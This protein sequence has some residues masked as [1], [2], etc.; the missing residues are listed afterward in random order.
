MVI[1]LSEVFQIRLV[2]S[3]LLYGGGLNL[4]IRSDITPEHA[5]FKRF[6]MP[7]Y[8]RL[9][10]E[11]MAFE[12]ISVRFFM[13]IGHNNLPSVRFHLLDDN[14]QISHIPTVFSPLAYH[15]QRFTQCPAAF[16]QN[17]V[18]VERDNVA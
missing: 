14:R 3:D 6:Y 1:S 5:S 17:F 2:Y 18:R 11:Q 10:C 9:R 13:S 8:I 7:P 12:H 4:E 15:K 16:P